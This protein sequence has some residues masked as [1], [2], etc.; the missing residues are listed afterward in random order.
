MENKSLG[1]NIQGQKSKVLVCRAKPVQKVGSSSGK[2]A[3]VMSVVKGLAKTQFFGHSV[4]KW[5]HKRCSGV[6]GSLESCK[7]FKMWK[8]SKCSCQC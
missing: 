2:M 7:N 5:I 6:K 1:V 4:G 8:M 3:A